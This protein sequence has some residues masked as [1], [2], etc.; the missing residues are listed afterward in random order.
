VMT[1][2]ATLLWTP[3]GVIIG[4]HLK[5]ARV[6][7]P[8]AQIAASFPV[9]MTFPL[10]VGFYAA[11][12]ISM[13]WGSILLIAMGTQWYILFNV[14]AGAMAIPNDLKEAA[15]SYGLRRWRLWLNL[16]LPAIFPY[17]VTGACTAAGGAWNASIVAEVAVWGQTTLK[18]NGLGAFISEV[19]EQ[20]NT[21]LIIC[22]IVTMSL[23][24]AITNKLLWRRLYGLAERRFHL[25]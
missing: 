17:W 6:A 19:T 8:L 5:L 24:V 21:P 1:L 15:R 14:I 9:N 7:E 3:I 2:I 25:D 11:H 22:S 10:V 18:A 13:D 20:G 4:S 23:F 16:I 12:H